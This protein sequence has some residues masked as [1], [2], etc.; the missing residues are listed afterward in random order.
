[1]QKKEEKREKSFT[2]CSNTIFDLVHIG[3]DVSLTSFDTRKINAS[4]QQV[5]LCVIDDQ[6]LGIAGRLWMLK[7]SAL[8]PLHPNGNPVSIPVHAL[9]HIATLVDEE[10]QSSRSNVHEEL[11]LDDSKE[12]IKTSS[13]VSRLGIEIDSQSG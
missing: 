13:H 3:R 11:V 4:E 6:M 12:T 9:D 2:S 8:E 1:V 7:A 5:Q 10:E